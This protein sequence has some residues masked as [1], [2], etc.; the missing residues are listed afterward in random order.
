VGDTTADLEA[1][2]AADV[3]WNIGVT[4]GAH[5]RA[6]LETCPH[7]ALLGSVAELPGWLTAHAAL[8]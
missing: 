6:R 4:S 5:P 1:G 3:G 2:A 8:R 7:T